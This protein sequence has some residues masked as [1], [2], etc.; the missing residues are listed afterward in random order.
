[1]RQSFRESRRP[2]S[3]VP[4]RCWHTL[5]L[6]T[7]ASKRKPQRAANRGDKRRRCE[8]DSSLDAGTI[9]GT[10]PPGDGHSGQ[11]GGLPPKGERV[12]SHDPPARP[13]HTATTRAPIEGPGHRLSLAGR[14]DKP[15]RPWERWLAQADSDRPAF[16][17][18]T[19]LS[20]PP[21]LPAYADCR[22]FS[23]QPS[24]RHHPDPIKGCDHPVHLPADLS[25]QR[26]GL[27]HSGTATPC[28]KQGNVTVLRRI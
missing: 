21:G 14:S 8:T 15:G 10:T 7:L 11:P 6:D 3:G 1:V 23:H 16:C 22:A 20:H 5:C 17:A 18:R 4:I 26:S 28:E 2:A 13:S 9:E 25:R 24:I 27:S 19:D 12:A